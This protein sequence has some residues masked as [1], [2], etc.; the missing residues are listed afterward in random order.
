MSTKNEPKLQQM[1]CLWSHVAFSSSLKLLSKHWEMKE[2]Q[3][4]HDSLMI[5][6]ISSTLAGRI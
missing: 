4:F 5:N 6:I 1:Q 3:L 2:I